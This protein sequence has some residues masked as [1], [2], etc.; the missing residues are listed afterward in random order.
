[1]MTDPI[2]RDDTSIPD[3][4]DAPDFTPEDEAIVDRLWDRIGRQERE[5]P[6]TKNARGFKPARFIKTTP[7]Y[8]KRG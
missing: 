2:S 1:M 8:A 5:A 3:T 7:G 6:G 4:G